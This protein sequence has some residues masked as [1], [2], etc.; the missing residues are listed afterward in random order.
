MHMSRYLPAREQHFP[1]FNSNQK[2]YIR[3]EEKNTERERSALKNYA[4]FQHVS[5][6]RNRGKLDSRGAGKSGGENIA[7]ASID[8]K[9]KMKN[10]EI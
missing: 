10:T 3:D 1:E 9:K 7:R 2:V 5:R 6:N 8:D 4:I